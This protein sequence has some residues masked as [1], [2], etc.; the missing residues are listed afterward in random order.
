M[1]ELKLG[2]TASGVTISP[3]GGLTNRSYVHPVAATTL[4]SRAWGVN[5]PSPIECICNIRYCKASATC[6]C[7]F[8][9]M[10]PFLGWNLYPPIIADLRCEQRGSTKKA[11]SPSACRIRKSSTADS[12]ADTLLVFAGN[13]LKP[14]AFIISTAERSSVCALCVPAG[15]TTIIT[16]QLEKRSYK[17][18]RMIVPVSYTHLRAHET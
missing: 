6:E 10:F 15:S 8:F 14:S 13:T 16:G 12:L 17:S 4:T 3:K 7:L 2:G 18:G 11:A 1:T 9:S 5:V